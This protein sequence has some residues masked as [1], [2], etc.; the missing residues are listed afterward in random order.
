MN[1]GVAKYSVDL[2]FFPLRVL[3]AFAVYAP[4]CSGAAENFRFGLPRRRE[5]REEDGGLETR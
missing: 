3:R 4:G 1:T 5:G 2:G